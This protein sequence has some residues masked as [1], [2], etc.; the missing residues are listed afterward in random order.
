M[1]SSISEST[2]GAH[3]QSTGP[4][5]L[6]YQGVGRRAV[7]VIIDSIVLLIP[8]YILGSVIASITGEGTSGGFQLEGGSAMLLFGLMAVIGF[9]YFILLEAFYG[10]TLGKRLVGIQVVSSDGTPIDLS[11]SVV[12]NVLRLIDGIF[13]YLVGAVFI[14]LSNSDQRLGDRVG[15]TV[16]VST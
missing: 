15:N 7:A 6:E 12:R 1:M 8:F 4:G 9:G 16:V 2:A 10:Q 5:E 14:W 11:A 13:M 3:E